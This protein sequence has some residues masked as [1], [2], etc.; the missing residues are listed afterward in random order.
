M[1]YGCSAILCVILKKASLFRTGTLLTTGS[2]VSS[3]REPT[4][5][6]KIIIVAMTT[7]VKEV[8]YEPADRGSLLT[9]FPVPSEF[10][11]GGYRI[12]ITPLAHFFERPFALP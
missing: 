11:C 2:Y 4:M 7:K 10:F 1:F 3:R 6:A 8:F 12:D 9:C 5:K